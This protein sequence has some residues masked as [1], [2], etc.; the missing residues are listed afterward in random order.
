M[1]G[2]DDLIGEALRST[3]GA[4]QPNMTGGGRGAGGELRRGAGRG[5]PGYPVPPEMEDPDERRFPALREGAGHSGMFIGLFLPPEVATLLALPDGEPAEALHVTLFYSKAGDIGQRM[6]AAQEAEHMFAQA[7]PIQATLG[8]IGRFS[9]SESS[10]GKDVIYVSVDSPQLQR[11]REALVAR[12][13]QVGVPVDTTHGFTPHVT[14]KYVDPSEPTPFTRVQPV[15]VRLSTL[16]AETGSPVCE[17]EAPLAK[18]PIPDDTAKDPTVTFSDLH[19]ES[20]SD[21][22]PG[23][24][25]QATV[26]KMAEVVQSF[27]DKLLARDID[28]RGGT[29]VGFGGNGVAFAL[30][31]DTVLKITKDRSE[32]N[33]AL[34]VKGKGLRNIVE[35]FDVFS[36]PGT[37]LF[38][39]WQE[40]LQPM[41]PADRNEFTEFVTDCEVESGMLSRLWMVG[42]DWDQI[43]YNCIDGAKE[44]DEATP[45]SVAR[46]TKEIDV[47]Q[48]K[49]QMDRMIRDLK[50]AQ[51]KFR[52]W[53]GGNIM[54][55]GKEHVLIDMGVSQS[56]KKQISALESIVR[57]VLPEA[58]PPPI[59]PDAGKRN[60]F[61]PDPPQ[62]KGP[63]PLP[64][65]QRPE[66][67][68][69]GGTVIGVKE[70]QARQLLQKNADRLAKKG[71]DVRRLQAIGQGTRG[72]AFAVGD[73]AL[74][75]T[76]DVQEAVAAN[77]LKG[78]GMKHVV[79]VDDVFKFQEGELYGV[80][81]ERLQPLEKKESNT[82]NF[83]LW[84][85]E[86]WGKGTEIPRLIYDSGYDWDKVKVMAT[87][88]LKKAL[89]A[90]PEN[91]RQE[92]AERANRAWKNLNDR[93]RIGDMVRELSSKGIR[94]HDY[95]AGNIMKR[96]NG[97]YVVIDIGYSKVAGGK[98]PPVLEAPATDRLAALKAA[99]L[100]KKAASGN[101]PE[102]LKRWEELLRKNG[103][104]PNGTLGKGNHGVAFSLPDG[105]VLKLTDDISEA[106]S[107]YHIKGKH[108]KHVVRIDDVF[109]LPGS[110]RFLIVQERLK[111]MSDAES[112]DFFDVAQMLQAAKVGQALLDGDYPR[113]VRKVE[114][115]YGED[116]ATAFDDTMRQ[117]QMPQILRELHTN[118]IEFLDFHPGNLMKRGTDYVVIDLGLSRSPG[119]DPPV[120]EDLVRGV[121][122]EFS[123]RERVHG[124]GPTPDRQEYVGPDA[125][126]VNHVQDGEVE[127]NARDIV[128]GR[129]D[130]VGVVSG[131][132]QPFH[133]GHA[134]AIRLATRGHTKTVVLVDVSPEGPFS[135]ETRLRMM[136]DSLP[137]VWSKMEVHRQEADGRPS[138]LFAAL[139]QLVEDGESASLK[140]GT[141]FEIL[142]E[143]GD[144][145]AARAALADA[146]KEHDDIF[147][148]SL[149]IVRALPETGTTD[150]QALQTVESDDR[151]GFRKLMD[152]HMV[153]DPGEV[154]EVFAE[155]RRE[156][157]NEG[158]TEDLNDIGGESGVEQVI[159]ASSQLLARRKPFPVVT[160]QL[161]RL[162]A[163]TDG[164]AFDMGGG[165]VF[166]VTS[167]PREARSSMSIAGKNLQHVGKIFDV[168]RFPEGAGN[169]RPVYG[170]VLEKLEPLSSAEAREFDAA[171]DWFLVEDVAKDT[172]PTG[173]WNRV[174][175]A[176][177]SSI[178]KRLS[179]KY[180]ISP[181]TPGQTVGTAPAKRQ[182]PVGT[183]PARRPKST[184][185][186]A[187]RKSDSMKREADEAFQT[188][189]ATMK[190]FQMDKMLQELKANGITFY[191]FHSGNMMKRGGQ[192]V[193]TDLGRS[194]SR[195]TEPPV[196]EAIVE[197]ILQEIGITFNTNSPGG[198]QAGLR[199]GSSGWS[200]PQEMYN[201]D[202]VRLAREEPDEF[203]MWS[204]QLKG[205]VTPG[206]VRQNT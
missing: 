11:F 56:P 190:K 89:S 27:A 200:S 206:K 37:K 163:G 103:L 136:E 73:K 134:D 169:G 128:E 7:G 157:G 65:S 196:M 26:I 85:P 23:K 162:G 45:E 24:L 3:Y 205:F 82:L 54:L 123:G 69:K 171:A 33:A 12:L 40:K 148:A 101:V 124:L 76:N 4:S 38:G 122:A 115:L 155:L 86:I 113:I 141:A 22:G 158:L 203:A 156:L 55:R 102:S 50:K 92:L 51:I 5:T 6:R 29:P 126:L 131:R 63:P 66:P 98:E 96:A 91:E 135:F 119:K 159:A 145:Q 10:D 198:T 17:G 18:S 13:T 57:A 179:Q 39:I 42:M 8:G 204:D 90:A 142:V 111:P 36:F 25:P 110:K 184:V 64:I 105:R 197:A 154:E 52:D 173:D 137:D 62:K 168:F 120:L 21:I 79:R 35:V 152:P 30:Q 191:D 201:D 112:Q 189:A 161:R 28:I 150:S 100:K 15:P 87:E 99:N 180:G 160:Q 107:S 83:D 67:R 140:A 32:A 177:R 81:Q 58:G 139:A 194:N 127:R 130:S 71:I 144:L 146:Q 182:A 109:Q 117:F 61:A 116:E 31:D 48:K 175:E 41:P 143:K 114:H 192:Y 151:E 72:V 176:L 193:V 188:T 199:A 181:E 80:L 16:R 53:H 138:D 19:E 106:R 97:D 132:F 121:M 60:V 202:D 70:E 49:Y 178:E 95:H 186:P 185:P 118:G 93:F 133:R 187:D 1:P 59:P 44:D 88:A 108:L 174:M 84:D 78:L 125:N 14:I 170:I 68:S 164:V 20:A 172:F 195:G 47:L 165:H 74:K 9:A 46:V 104:V 153:S 77:K 94:F 34:V 149:A 166:K 75:V 183:A 167:D 129:T 43:K 2:L 147:D